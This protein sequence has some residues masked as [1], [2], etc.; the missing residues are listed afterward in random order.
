[1][2]VQPS[3]GEA[4][5]RPVPPAVVTV[6]DARGVDSVVG[7]QVVDRAAAGRPAD[8]RAAEADTAAVRVFFP[9]TARLGHLVQP[10]CFF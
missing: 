5:D 6:A 10:G 7:N 4:A 9:R 1:M 3:S 2:G 8:N